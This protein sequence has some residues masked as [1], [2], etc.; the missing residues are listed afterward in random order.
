M[1]ATYGTG[2]IMAVPAHDERDFAFA[3]QFGLSIRTV[4]RPPD[5]WLKKTGN[6]GRVVVA[7]RAADHLLQPRQV[8]RDRPEGRI[9]SGTHRDRRRS[10]SGVP[11]KSQISWGG[12]VGSSPRG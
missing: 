1:L 6:R 10:P 11:A 2:A 12:K 9:G 7:K 8:G 4:V 3:R 5:D